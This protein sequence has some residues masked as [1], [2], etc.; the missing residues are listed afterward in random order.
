MSSLLYLIQEKILS[1]YT[2]KG[3]NYD[4]LFVILEGL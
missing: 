1:E 2:K 4:I 3:S